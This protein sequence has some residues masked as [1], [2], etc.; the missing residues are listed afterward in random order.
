MCDTFGTIQKAT[1]C[2]IN[3]GAKDVILA[4]THGIFS[5]PAIDRMNNTEDV[6]MVICSDSIPQILN[7]QKRKIQLPQ[8]MTRKKTKV[9]IL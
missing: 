9:M 2:L 7:Q 6:K 8:M 5:G 3:N 1:K 4:I